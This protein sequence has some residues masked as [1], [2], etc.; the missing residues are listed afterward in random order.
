MATLSVLCLVP[1][2]AKAC[3]NEETSSLASFGRGPGDS[4]IPGD[5][6]MNSTP[7]EGVWAGVAG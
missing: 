3:G 7:C 6:T 2:P 5:C 4:A 1:A